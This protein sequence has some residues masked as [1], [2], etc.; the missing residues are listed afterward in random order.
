MELDINSER[1]LQDLGI[2]YT[3]KGNHFKFHCLNPN[4]N[5]KNPSMTMLKD[6]GFSRCWSCGQTYTLAQLIRLVSGKSFYEYFDIKN[7]ND[8]KF[9]S[10]LNTVHEYKPKELLKRELILE[11]SFTSVYDNDEALQYC[12]SIGITDRMINIFSITSA[13]NIKAKFYSN[14]E[15]GTYL[16]KRIIIPVKVNNKIVNLEARDYTGSQ[17]PKVLYPKGGLSDTLF[18]YE[19]INLDKPVIVV[20]GIKS[21]LRL[22]KLGY[23]NIVSTFGVSLGIKQK[24]MLNTID[25]IILFPDHDEAGLQMIEKFEKFYDKEYSIALMPEVGQDPFDGTEQDVIIT[26]NNTINSTKYF[27]NKYDLID[28]KIT[29][30]F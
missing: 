28:K 26:L 11:G 9:K 18:N 22:F 4:H 20:E 29:S 21:L 19:Y 17:T 24:E 25:N 14:I 6:S 7:V 3:D 8:F 15:K 30:W 12:Y 23:T 2:Q 16:N 27:L 1:V 5:D 10:L 13:V